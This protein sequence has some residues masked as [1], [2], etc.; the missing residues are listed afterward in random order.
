[1]SVP[2]LVS[3]GARFTC[4]PC[5]FCCGF[6]DIQI[7]RQRKDSLEQKDWVKTLSRDLDALKHESLF[8]ILGQSN[9]LLI[10]RRGG[11]CGFLDSQ[12][13][14]S[15][16]A[17]DGFDAKPMVCQQYPNVYYETPRGVEVFLDHSCPEVI[18]NAGEPVTPQVVARTLPREYVQKA[19]STFPLNSR[20]TLDWDGYLCLEEAFLR[21]LAKPM[22]CDDRILHLDQL[23]KELGRKLENHPSPLRN[24]VG[25][26]LVEI[27]AADMTHLSK[28]VQQLP[29]NPSKRDLYLAILVQWVESTFSAEVSGAAM[30]S[31]RVIRNILTQW[32]GIGDHTFEVFK[33]RVNY[34]HMRSIGFSV[35]ASALR[36]PLDRYLDYQVRTLVGTGKIS[37][38]R[39]LGIIAT[40]FA[41]VRWLSRAHA[42]SNG[43][44]QV[45]LDDIVFGIKVVEKFLSNR[46]FNKLS[47]QKSFLSNYINLL[48]DNPSLPGTM[49]SRP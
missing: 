37:I 35:N 16:H 28:K 5:G 40:N 41:L 25:E 17:A 10:R 30:G 34:T 20:T 24:T 12:M 3:P 45:S 42:A 31:G 9:Q 2:I 23:A 39:R 44:A 32:R 27:E 48:F 22:D 36:E 19:D 15:I 1:M 26:A 21:I 49:L 8:R 33:F 38:T 4:V 43:T 18:R 47:Q 11:S 14:C 6:W 7:D 29:Y 46:L 13:L